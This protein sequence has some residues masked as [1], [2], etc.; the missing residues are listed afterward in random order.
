MSNTRPAGMTTGEVRRSIYRAHFH[1]RPNVFFLLSKKSRKH[2]ERRV[3]SFRTSFSSRYCHIIRGNHEDTIEKKIKEDMYEA[4]SRPLLFTCNIFRLA[5]SLS[6]AYPHF[7][8]Y[9]SFFSAAP[10]LFVFAFDLD[11]DLSVLS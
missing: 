3:D 9:F 8:S 5:S 10:F 6:R 11:F 7:S 2:N 1:S 4:I